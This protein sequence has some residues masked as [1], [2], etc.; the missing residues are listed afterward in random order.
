[1]ETA[2]IVPANGKVQQARQERRANRN[3]HRKSIDASDNVVES[4]DIV[5]PSLSHAQLDFAVKTLTDHQLF[6]SLKKS[7]LKKVCAEMVSAVADPGKYI[8]K[9]GDPGTCFFIIHQGTVDVQIDNEHVRTL[10]PGQTFGELAMLFK[11][12]RTASIVC[13]DQSCSF[14]VMKPNLYKKTLQ[15]MRLEEEK[16]NLLTIEKVP[17]FSCLTNKQKFSLTSAI[18]E[19]RFAEGERIF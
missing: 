8:F 13:K 2:S 14:L 12:P 9:Q 10:S 5:G 7:E 18:K 16:R 11:T 3:Y 4:V 15:K 6:S 19:M 17:L 1:M